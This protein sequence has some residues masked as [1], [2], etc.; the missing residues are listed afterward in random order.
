MEVVGGPG[1]A[2]PGL[3]EEHRLE[4]L[5]V[6]GRH[7]VVEDRVEGG[8]EEV[9][10][11]GEV[12]EVLVDG[13][14]GLVLPEVDVAEALEVEGEPGDEEEDHHGDWGQEVR[15]GRDPNFSYFYKLCT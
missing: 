15:G 6:L 9:E 1:G 14:E 8:G 7:Q 5:P 4:L 2:V 11:A 3:A 13:A 12:E 10:A